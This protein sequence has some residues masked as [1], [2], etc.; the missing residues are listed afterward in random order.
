MRKY[1]VRVY[2]SAIEFWNVEAKSEQEAMDNYME[3]ENYFT[4]PKGEDIEILEE[5]K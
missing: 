4:K 5:G 1:K 3:G 2:T